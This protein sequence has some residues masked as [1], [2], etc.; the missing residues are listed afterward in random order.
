MMRMRFHPLRPRVISLLAAVFVVVIAI[1]PQA[2]AQSTEGITALQ[3]AQLQSVSSAILSSDGRYIVFTRSIPADPYIDNSPASSELFLYDTETQQERAIYN[4]GRASGVAFR[5][6]HNTITFLARREGDSGNVLYELELTGGEPNRLYSHTT[7]ISTYSWAPDGNRFV[8]VSEEVLDLPDTV[9]PYQP[10]IFEEN[11][12]NRSGFIA[13]VGGEAPLQI[14]IPG[15]VHRISWNHDGSALAVGVAPSATV[16][17][18]YM[19]IR[20]YVVDP[21]SGMVTAEVENEGK[22][23]Q[24]EWSPDGT[25]LALRAA[26]HINDPIDGRILIALATGGSPQIILPEFEG[27]FEQI[28]W[29]A[30]G[31]I[32][33][34]ASEGAHRSFGT[35]HPDGSNLTRIIDPSNLIMTRFTEP[36]AGKIAFVANTPSHPGELYLLDVG[37]RQPKRLTTS[38]SWLDEVRLGRQEVITYPTRDGAY[39]IEGMLIYPLDYVEGSRVPLITVVHGGPEAHYNNGW[40]TSYS[41]PGQLGAARGYAVFYPNYRGSTGRGIAFAMSSQGDL[42]GAEFDDIVDGV[43]YLV[44]TGIAD[45]EHVGVTGGSYGGYATAWMSTRYSDRFAAG[46]M[47]VGISN[48]LSKWGTSDIPEE[49]YHVHARTRI[50]ED[51]QGYLES[52]PIYWVDQAETPLLIMHGKEDTRVHPG[53]SLELFRHLKVRRP[54]VPVRL[55][56]YPGEGHGNARATARY[57][58]NLRM[59]QW[60]DTYLKGDGAEMPHSHLEADPAVQLAN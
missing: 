16:D 32:H 36:Q 18:S 25:R 56:W 47:S 11:V 8:F 59:M 13:T 37:E 10:E 35:L 27:K 15:T 49:L 31:L 45:S 20:V 29:S 12:P 26:A 42:A 57:D 21:S 51:W 44:S 3:V 53:Q 19:A 54:E 22:I 50:W 23:G 55:V 48:N 7:S 52:S 14:Q 38:N 58:F 2:R 33:F 4:D 39:E 30:D 34:L 28:A 60:F 1:A 17:D 6:G 5:P 9:L 46:V 41:M 40:L 43:D 24:I